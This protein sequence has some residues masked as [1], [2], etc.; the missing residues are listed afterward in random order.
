MVVIGSGATA[1]TLVPALADSGAEHVTMLQRS[2]SYILSLPERDPIADKLREKLPAHT[3][4]AIVR[5]KNVLLGMLNYQLCR[6]APTAMRRLLRGLAGKQLPPGY[7]LDTH[8]S[9][10]YDPW[11]QRLCLVPDGDLF[12]TLS[13]GGASIETGEIETFTERGIALASG[14]Q[15]DADVI[16]TATGLNM[17]MLGGIELAVD[18]RRDRARQHRRLQGHDARRRAQPRAHRRLHERVVDAQGRP[19][20]RI[21]VPRAQPHGRAR[22]GRVHARGPRCV[23]LPRVPI[24]DLKSGYVLRSV[25]QLPKQGATAPWRLHQNYIKDV[26][27]L[28]RG[29]I[30]DGVEFSTRERSVPGELLDGLVAANGSRGASARPHDPA[31]GGCPMSAAAAP[32]RIARSRAS[33]TAI[34]RRRSTAC[35]PGRALP[36]SMQTLAMRTRQR[37]YLERARRRY[38]SMFTISVVGLGQR[39]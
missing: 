25:D 7:D 35:R 33:R 38:G 26:R 18:G 8:F 5:W 4:Y 2:P 16:V 17:M 6:R 15:L 13:G 12:K 32:W 29:P 28:R 21:R 9:P 27:L 23:D 11:D 31:T 20:R 34:G 3:A 24:I 10:R 22:T 37:P 39:R 19:R 14:K 30:D 1:V 36:M